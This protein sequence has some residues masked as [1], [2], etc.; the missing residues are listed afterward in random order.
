MT[1]LAI[2]PIT[3]ADVGFLEAMLVEA[4]YWRQD[5]PRPPVAEVLHDPDLAVYLEGWGRRGDHGLV[6]RVSDGPAGAVWVRSFDRDRHG[7]GYVDDR[8]P[9]LTIAVDAPHRRRGIARCLMSSMLAHQRLNGVPA[10]SLSV[11]R[12]NPAVTLY[13][14]LGFEVHEQT[15]SDQTMVCRL[16]R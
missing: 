9:E 15:S 10:V 13:A 2:L 11:E 3:A 5:T 1:S 7:Y 12:E 14:Q 8:I 16:E 4:A 6:A